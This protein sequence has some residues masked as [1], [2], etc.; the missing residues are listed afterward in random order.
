V[1]SAE[2]RPDDT[3]V[4]TGTWWNPSHRIRLTDT[5]TPTSVSPIRTLA[6]SALV[7]AALLAPAAGRAQLPSTRPEAYAAPRHWIGGDFNVAQPVGDLDR[8]I[9]NGYGGSANYVY[10]LGRRGILGLRVDAAFLNYGNE[11]QNICFNLQTCRVQ[12]HLTTSNNIVT[13][14]VG[15]Q[16]TVPSGPIRPYVAGSI[17]FS[18]F[19]TQSRIRFDGNSHGS[20]PSTTNYDDGGLAWQGTAGLLIPVSSGRVPVAIDLAA[21][22]NGNGQRSYLKKGSIT[23]NGPGEAPTIAP[24]RTEANFVTYHVG[25]S[26][27]LRSRSRE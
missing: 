26:V 23:D 14:G 27:G 10:A 24:I 1:P 25:V 5:A 2:D 22:F 12:G 11:R 18:Y 3:G 6:R 7:G 4:D 21:R 17:G 9:G 8:V 16:L 19:F 20:D 15:P 13:A